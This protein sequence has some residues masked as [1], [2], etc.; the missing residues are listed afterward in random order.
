MR[1]IITKRR[2]FFQGVAA[3]LA[4]TPLFPLRSEAG[5]TPYPKRLIWFFT[6]N[7]TVMDEWWPSADFQLGPILTPL[8]SFKERLVVMRGID[9]ETALVEPRPKDHW[10]DFMNQLTARQGTINPDETCKIGGISIDQHIAAGLAGTTPYPSL[11]LGVKCNAPQARV[12]ALGPNQPIAPQN[13]P[14]AAFDSLFSDLDLDP[15]GLAKLRAERRSVLD[16]VMDE[17]SAI[18]AQTSGT[19]R[20]KLQAHLAALQGLEGII[21]GGGGGASCAAPMLDPVDLGDDAQI[22]DVATQQFRIA[23]MALA[24]DLTRVMTL[25]VSQ[26]ASQLTHP[27]LDIN[28]SHHGIS[29]G[30][31]GVAATEEQRRQWL[32]QI[33][34]WYAERFAELLGLLDAI[35]EGGPGQS[36]LDHSLVVWAHEQQNGATHNRRDMPYVLAG[37]LHG[38]VETGRRVDA[39]GVPHNGLL[40][41]LA[42]LMDVPTTEFGDPA[43]SSGALPELWG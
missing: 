38:T 26:S 30:S 8:Q 3:A 31:E 27:W 7:G 20:E 15:L 4:A 5:G 17:V 23:Q 35:D 19:D 32:I 2:S 10:P 25:Q 39:G 28:N 13:N 9:H 22:P 11:H 18:E 12:S 36:M 42:N 41:A 16:T 1:G 6:P 29:H 37:G 34:T 43:F 40:I 21:E 24:C 14:A 33:E